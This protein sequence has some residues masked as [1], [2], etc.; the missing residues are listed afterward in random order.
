MPTAETHTQIY[1]PGASYP[2]DGSRPTTLF[3]VGISY[4]KSSSL[5]SGASTLYFSIKTGAMEGSAKAVTATISALG[6]TCLTWAV[7]VCPSP[8]IFRSMT[9]DVRL[10]SF[11]E[12]DR[13][14]RIGHLRYDF[15]FLSSLQQLSFHGSKF[16]YIIS[17]KHL[18]RHRPHL[19]SS[20][21]S[22]LGETQERKDPE[23]QTFAST[24]P[25]GR[26]NL[27]SHCP[28]L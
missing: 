18:Y 12:F 23:M 21:F 19:E 24:F 22:V 4:S 28:P 1:R 3:I 2:S 16:R 27:A 25:A 7:A 15:E 11:R 8:G 13:F 14:D 26:H 10:R 20:L 17:N 6:Y 9:N 5:G